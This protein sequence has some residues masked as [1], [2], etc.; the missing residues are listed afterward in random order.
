M[1]HAQARNTSRQAEIL[2]EWEIG[3]EAAGKIGEE[4]VCHVCRSR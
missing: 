1:L 3:E 2:T 4:V